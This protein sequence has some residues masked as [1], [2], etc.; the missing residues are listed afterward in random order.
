[1]AITR[2]TALRA[3][4]RQ[5]TNGG[6]VLDPT[7]ELELVPRNC[8]LTTYMKLA[9]VPRIDLSDQLIAYSSPDSTYAVT[10]RIFDAAR[11]SIVIGIYDFT[12]T[13]MRD[14]LAKAM[15][16]GVKVSLM[17]DIDTPEELV[18][19]KALARKGCR[20]VAAPSCASK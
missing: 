5:E 17:L 8:T 2:K 14:L 16:R 3:H 20:S 13:Y 11:K 18:I 12:A 1:M 19:F 15:A 4:S 6:Q 7:L 9:S 10:K